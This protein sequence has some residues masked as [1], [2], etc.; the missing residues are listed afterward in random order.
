MRCISKRWNTLHPRNKLYFS[1]QYRSIIFYTVASLLLAVALMLTGV[2]DL[3]ILF[4]YERPD[5]T[6][7]SGFITVMVSLLKTRLIK[8]AKIQSFSA[9]TSCSSILSF[10][11]WISSL[12]WNK[13]V[14]TD[15][16]LCN[17]RRYVTIINDNH[18]MCISFF[19]FS[20]QSFRYSL[21]PTENCPR[22][23]VIRFLSNRVCTFLAQINVIFVANHCLLLLNQSKL[24]I[25]YNQVSPISST[26]SL[27]H[28]YKKHS[29]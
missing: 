1:L 21:S 12:T 20:S 10:C 13:V 3:I 29:V 18:D 28:M 8:V 6:T 2:I 5:L 17:I 24:I 27:I 9:A 19:F 16:I 11:V 23:G 4:E 7:H 14:S 22:G 26:Q 15:Q 25:N